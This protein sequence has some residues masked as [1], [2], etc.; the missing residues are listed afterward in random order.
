MTAIVLCFVAGVGLLSLGVCFWRNAF[1]LASAYQGH[2][3]SIRFYG[4]MSE[5]VFRRL[6]GGGTVAFAILLL[7]VGIGAAAS[8]G[9]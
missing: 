9:S 7:A 1:G 2:L 4:D 8:S 6:L 5:D 3:S